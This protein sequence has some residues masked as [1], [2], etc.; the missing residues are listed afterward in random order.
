MC[1]GDPVADA[2][3]ASCKEEQA[4][5]SALTRDGDK[6]GIGKAQPPAHVA[7]R[8]TRGA[9]LHFAAANN[10]RKAMGTDDAASL[11]CCIKIPAR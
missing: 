4:G 8:V 6:S 7:D 9:A 11:Q 2:L 1:L 5:A 3:H 10:G